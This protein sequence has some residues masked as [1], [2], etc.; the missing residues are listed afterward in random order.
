[1]DLSDKEFKV[2]IPNVVKEIKYKNWLENWKL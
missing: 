1:M 2:T